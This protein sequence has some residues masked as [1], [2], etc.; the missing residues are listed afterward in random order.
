MIAKPLTK[1]GS[2]KKKGTATSK[3]PVLA[4]DIIC[5]VG[6]GIYVVQHGNFVYVSP[7]FQE[8][9]GYAEDEMLGKHSLEHVYPDDRQMVRD[10]ATKRLKGES[11]GSYE[12][13]FVKKNGEV[14]S[15][16]EMVKSI[17]YHGERA[18]VGSFMDITD[19]K[20]QDE[21][22]KASE[23]RFRELFQNMTNGVAI[24]E[25]T[26]N[27][28][29]FILKDFNCAAENMEHIKKE[30]VIGKSVL[31]IFPGVK[32]FG[33]FDVFQRVWRSGKAEHF[34]IAHYHDER[35]EG[36]R[37]N[38]VYKL[39]SGEI[40]AVYDDITERKKME[41]QLG[42]MATHD[43][44]TGLPNR[45]LF[46]DRLTLALAHAQRNHYKLAVMMLDL[47]RF[48][49]VNDT[50][51]HDIGDQLLKTMADRFIA[52]LRKSD[53][54]A[55]IG[56]DE[57]MIL[58]PEL[59]ETDYAVMVAWKILDDCRQPFTINDYEICLTASIGIT[60]YPD[61]GEEIVTLLKNADVAMYLSKNSGGNRCRMF[62]DT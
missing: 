59:T 42:F 27:G 7:L 49:D 13:R 34:P 1:G 23:L 4:H 36:W 11:A 50:L 32:E 21:A 28:E 60:I 46:F 56:G 5:S 52:L 51:G 14:I 37:E 19:R 39:P 3:M 25:A 12:Y 17:V 24:Y 47:D 57:F 44:L 62:A 53:T 41:Q 20:Q 16:L 40:V 22:I 15:I 38:Y 45:M 55:R 9:T 61:E 58:L 48:K 43:V 30:A 29:D 2:A 54:V 26:A 6:V 8:L 10:M 31:K 33:L 18:A 35:I